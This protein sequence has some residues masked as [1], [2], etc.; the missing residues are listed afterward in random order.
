MRKITNIGTVLMLAVM[1]VMM[2]ISMQTG[3]NARGNVDTDSIGTT[4]DIPLTALTNPYC[5]WIR[6]GSNL[7]WDGD[8]LETAPAYSS[9]AIA[10]T[11]NSNTLLYPWS[12]PSGLANGFYAVPFYDNASPVNTDTVALIKYVRVFDGSFVGIYEYLN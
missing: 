8:S 5:R 1:A 9:Q 6:C 10:L 4:I 11:K 7:I 12:V 3:V 2:L